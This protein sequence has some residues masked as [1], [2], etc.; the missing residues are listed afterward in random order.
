MVRHLLPVALFADASHPL[1][2]AHSRLHAVDRAVEQVPVQ[3]GRR[4]SVECQDGQDSVV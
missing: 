2:G 3:N 4:K 1:A